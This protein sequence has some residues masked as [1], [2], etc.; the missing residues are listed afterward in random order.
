MN[1]MLETLTV[2]ELRKHIENCRMVLE[3]KENAKRNKLIGDL[4]SAAQELLN[5][6][7]FMTVSVTAYCEECEKEIDVDIDLKYLTYE[8]NYIE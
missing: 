6:C 5:E 3:S 8:D 2:E 7:P 4:A 1:E